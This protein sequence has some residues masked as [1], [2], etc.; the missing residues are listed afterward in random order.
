MDESNQ[1]QASLAVERARTYFAEVHER[2]LPTLPAAI[3][4]RVTAELLRH[5]EALLEVVD[6]IFLPVPPSDSE[7]G[8]AAAALLAEVPESE[9][10]REGHRHRDPAW[11]ASTIIGAIGDDTAA[12]VARWLRAARREGLTA[13]QRETLATVLGDAIAYWQREASVPCTDCEDA[14]TDLCDDHAADLDRV[15]TYKALAS[16]LGVEVQS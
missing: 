2:D 14:A 13:A 1:S 4:E 10:A 3:R 6:D 5:G 7:K 9:R 16:E 12:I 8:R 11:A 15:D